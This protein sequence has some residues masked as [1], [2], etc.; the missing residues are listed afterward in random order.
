MK[1]GFTFDS[2]ERQYREA[3]A[4]G[5]RFLTCQQFVLEKGGLKS[6]DKVIVNRV[7]IDFAGKKTARLVDIFD[8]LGIKATFFLRLHAPEYNPFSFEMYRIIK[9]LVE[10]GHE[11]GY[12]SEVIDQAAIWEEDPSDCLLKDIDIINRMFDVKIQGVASHGGTTGL[13]N[14]DFWRD[15]KP[16]DFGLLYEGYDHQPEFNLFQE[17]FYVSDS[18]WTRWKCYDKGRL[19]E[20]NR[21]SLAEHARDGHP[22]IY[23]LIHPDTY[24]DNNFYE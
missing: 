5:Y 4:L 15:K 19:L 13:N 21:K 2:I 6:T 23:L 16:G 9:H 7:D 3:V 1:S 11:L 17:A 10:S 8:R 14:L 12:H 20:G 24:F 22:L 18:E